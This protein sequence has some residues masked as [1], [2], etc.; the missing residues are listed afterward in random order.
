MKI[1]PANI[2]D[3]SMILKI[4]NLSF[5]SPWTETHFQYELK[6]NPYAFVFVAEAEGYVVGYIDFWITFQ[7]A[8]INNLAVLPTLRKQGIGNVI[9]MD[10]L[11]RIKHAGCESIT[12]E[13][14]VS[15][16]IAQKLYAKHGF[17]KLIKKSRYYADGEDAWL[18]EMRL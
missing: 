9:L 7:Q 2:E 16:Q 8:Q 1:R 3:L 10:A 17:K 15:N 5:S 11:E 13:V 18:M 6:Q 12:L 14:R 4:E